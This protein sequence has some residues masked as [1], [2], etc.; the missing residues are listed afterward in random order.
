MT[1]KPTKREQ[2]QILNLAIHLLDMDRPSDRMKKSWDRQYPLWRQSPNLLK[3]YVDQRL[4]EDFYIEELEE[5][6]RK[7]K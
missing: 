6:L 2:R 7:I 3:I 5:A 4:L 1:K